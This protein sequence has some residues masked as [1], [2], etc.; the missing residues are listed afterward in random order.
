MDETGNASS[1]HSTEKETFPETPSGFRTPNF[2]HIKEEKNKEI[3][4]FINNFINNT[5][6]DVNNNRSIYRVLIFIR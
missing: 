2:E 3:K 5:D 4:Q 1:H 6:P